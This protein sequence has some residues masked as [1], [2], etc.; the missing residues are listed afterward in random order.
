MHYDIIGDI[1]GHADALEKL[2]QKLGY[3]LSNG[4][5]RHPEKRNVIFLGDYID[6]GPKIRETLHIVKNMCD[7]GNAVAIMGNHEFNAVCFAKK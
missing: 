4:I 6:R 2:L 5:Y 7:A 3:T 1:H